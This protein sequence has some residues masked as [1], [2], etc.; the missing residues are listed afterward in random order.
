ME[1]REIH[2]E[3]WELIRGDSHI[4]ALALLDQSVEEYPGCVELIATRAFV[5]MRMGNMADALKE[6]DKVIA[7]DP[8]VILAMLVAADCACELGRLGHA[9]TYYEQALQQTDDD[10]NV[11]CEYAHFLA[12]HRGPRVAEEVAQ[13]AVKVSPKSSEAWSALGMAQFRL[14]EHA[15]AESSLQRALALNPNDDRA[16]WYL[17]WILQETDRVGEAES[18]GSLIESPEL[19][20]FKKS[21]HA[22]NVRRKSLDMLFQRQDFC[23]S[24]FGAEQHRGIRRYAIPIIKGMVIT[25][26][27]VIALTLT[28]HPITMVPAIVILWLWWK[29]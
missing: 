17:S 28:P 23:D 1:L 6:A 11:L 10:P 7:Q 3:A 29:D 20:E 22:S 9:Q 27:I 21:L 16:K 14:H 18:L 13:K 15:V 4:S 8:S 12:V 25:I 5:L 19:E 24:F 26:V 2:D